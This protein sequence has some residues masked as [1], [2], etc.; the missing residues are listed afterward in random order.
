MQSLVEIGQVVL[1]KKM[2]MC[3]K[4]TDR[5]TVGWTTNKKVIRKAQV[6]Y[7]I[8][9]KRHFAAHVTDVYKCACKSY[10][11]ECLGKQILSTVDQI[12]ILLKFHVQ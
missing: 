2:K 7:K 10:I 3:G 4:F 9:I 6:S 5:W 12:I 8:L 1:E 11:N